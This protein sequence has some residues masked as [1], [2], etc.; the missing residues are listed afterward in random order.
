[1]GNRFKGGPTFLEW[2][3]Q[4][5]Q[6]INDLIDYVNTIRGIPTGGTA[7]QVLTKIDDT[8]YNV[9]WQDGGGGGG[10]SNIAWLPN[11]TPEGELSWTRSSSTTPPDPVNIKGEDG[12]NGA[13][14][15]F[16]NPT[17]TANTIANT[18]PA[19][20]EV[21]ASGPDTAKVFSF[22]FGIPKG[23]DGTDGRDG[24]QGPAG[25]AAGFGTITATASSVSGQPTASVK[26]TGPDTAKN[27]AFTFG[28]PS[29]GGGGGGGGDV[30]LSGNNNF[31][32]KNTFSQPIEIPDA[33]LSNE[34]VTLQQMEDELELIHQ[35]PT[36]S[37]VDAGKVLTVNES[38]VWEPSSDIPDDID[39]LSEGLGTANKAIQQLENGTLH[40]MESTGTAG[41]VWQKG[42]GDSGSWKT[43]PEPTPGEPGTPAGFGTPTA[44]AKTLESGES[45]TVEVNA[46]GPDTAKVFSFS[47][48]IPKGKDG[49]DG[50]N[51]SDGAPG[52]AAGFGT[53]TATASSVSGQPT[54]SVQATGPDTA[55]NLAFT[56]GIPSGGGGGGDVE[57]QVLNG[58]INTVGS[59]VEVA[60][61]ATYCKMV[62]IGNFGFGYF[63]V[64]KKSGTGAGT[65]T[66]FTAS[67]SGQSFTKGLFGRFW[68]SDSSSNYNLS[69]SVSSGT[70]TLNASE[71][72]YSSWSIPTATGATY[73]GGFFTVL[74]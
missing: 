11:V 9:G 32:G 46:S 22:S 21:N 48:G 8:D 70:I 65:L 12:Q 34:A 23:K 57:A 74:F 55:K 59:S 71:A 42:D 17:A 56:F 61:G 36:V 45:A 1:M 47:F 67:F 60:A 31:T 6:K 40:T 72:D 26:A 68:E 64:K 69:V 52:A 18:E 10:T 54:A 16:G 25:A 41:Q 20:V 37:A 44:S 39:R 24:G 14:A 2:W 66:G 29:G 3:A 53:I 15:G 73:F 35:L 50:T 63:A 19:T 30:F 27:L 7:G 33:T 28:I 38:G 49:T 62:K 4:T 58:T 13:A 51:G 5:C 43:L